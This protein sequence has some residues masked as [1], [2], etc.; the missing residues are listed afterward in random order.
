MYHIEHIRM[1]IDTAP[2][3]LRSTRV[4]GELPSPGE[5]TELGNLLLSAY[6]D[7]S[8]LPRKPY[9]RL[10]GRPAAAEA[11]RLMND[12]GEEIFRYDLHDLCEG[13]QRS[14]L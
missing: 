2:E 10:W 4:F 8:L 6:Y 13:R 9:G 1:E 14:R 7:E 5:A 3:V 11:I 12:R